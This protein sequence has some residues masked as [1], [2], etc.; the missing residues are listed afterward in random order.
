MKTDY[1]C[2]RFERE[3]RYNQTVWMIVSSKDKEGN[4]S[5]E[6]RRQK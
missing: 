2:T 3:A 5:E 6:A 4:K 1:F